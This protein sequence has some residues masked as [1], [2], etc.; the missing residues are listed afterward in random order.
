MSLFSTIQSSATALQVNQLGLQVVS[1]N[2]ANANTPGYIRQELVQSTGPS[3]LVGGV[4]LGYGVRATGVQQKYDQFTADQLRSTSSELAMSKT[5]DDNYGQIES[6]FNEMTSID[7]STK[8]SNFSNSIQ[9]ALN[10]PGNTSLKRLV[11]EQGQ[12]LATSIR[13]IDSQ[14]Q[15]VQKQINQGIHSAATEINRLIGGIAKLN[16]QIVKMEGGGAVASDAV[17]LRDQREQLLNSLA[18]YIDIHTSEQTSGSMTVFVGGDY[19][20]AEGIQRPVTV[21]LN[22]NGEKSFFEIRTADTDMPL[23]IAGGQVKGLYDSRD[24]AAG[25]VSAKLDEFTRTLIEQFNTIHSQGQGTSGFNKVTGTYAADDVSAPLDLAGLPVQVQN[26]EFEIQVSDF[27]TG[28]TNTHVIRVR[29]TGGTDDTTLEDVRAAIQAISGL[30]AK[31]TPD[32]KLQINSA[33]EKISFSFQNDSSKFLAAVGI[34][35]FFTGTNASTIAVNSVVAGNPA[36][37]AASL[38]GVGGGTDNALLLAQAFDQPINRLNGESLKQSFETMV[39]NTTQDI[40]VQAGITDGLA[41]F[42]KVLESKLIGITGVNL[43]EEAVKMIYYQRAFQ[44]NSRVIQASSD[45]LDV[46]MQL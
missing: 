36:M 38:S 29:I 40:N 15:G 12:T 10:Q 22:D 45:M 21:K 31:L 41:N 18:N 3:V 35:T 25:N 37:F 34:N 42:Q 8:M 6:L 26:G 4:V 43:D 17:G 1:N 11:V 27:Q 7:L 46:L 23:Q 2:V 20:V 44:A 24:K 33:S 14:L 9:D 30:N 32:G 39:I 16:V 13:K 28:L 5:L 19:L